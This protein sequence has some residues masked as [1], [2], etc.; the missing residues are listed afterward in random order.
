MQVRST[1]VPQMAEYNYPRHKAGDDRDARRDERDGGIDIPPERKIAEHGFQL[2]PAGGRPQPG[3]HG[4]RPEEGE[5]REPAADR[6]PAQ[7]QLKKMPLE[8]ARNIAVGGADKMQNFDDLAMARHGAL[9]RESHRQNHRS[10]DKGEDH[11]GGEDNA[12]RHDRE[13]LQPDAMVV[14]SGAR[15]GAGEP[16]A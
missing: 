10:E 15:N 14:D 2:I 8:L 4:C 7:A 6:A 12:L 1:Q 3:S 9:G 16:F 11:R 5:D 13:T